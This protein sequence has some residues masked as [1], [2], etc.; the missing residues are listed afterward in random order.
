MMKKIL[1]AA[2]LAMAIVAPAH[3]EV[4]TVCL[5]EAVSSRAISHGTNG[6]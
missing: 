5:G 1:A 3:T 6:Q 4:G 2:A